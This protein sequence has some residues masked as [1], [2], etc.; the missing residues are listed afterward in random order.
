MRLRDLIFAALAVALLVGYVAA[1]QRVGPLLAPVAAARSTPPKPSGPVAAPM[2]RG[3]LAFV[4]RGDVYVLSGGSYQ[5]RTSDGRAQ[6]TALSPDGRTLYFARVE[7]ID[8]QREVDGQIVPAHLGYSNIVRKA[9]GGTEEVLLSGLTRA[10]GSSR[11]HTVRWYL[12]P[13]ASPD[14]ARLAIIEADADG[15]SDLLVYDLAT[16]K[17]TTPFLSNGADWSDPAWSPDGKTIVVT[18]YDTGEPRLLLKPTDGKPSIAVKGLP[19]GEPYRASYSADGK[20][21]IYTLRHD[22][23]RKNDLHAFE[24]ATGRDVA[25]TTDGQT[26]NGIFSPDGTQIAFLRADHFTIDLWFA[27]VGT[28]LVTGVA[29]KDAVKVTHGEGIDGAVRPSWG[30]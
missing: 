18:S 30:R 21:L 24:L 22:D 28:S 14:G 3:T 12:A 15:S 6:Q 27:E 1:A 26:W 10:P 16:K 9:P 13:A 23:G 19:D 8:G 11:F 5:P 17:L 25:L 4:L 20:W 29:P 7:E 2:V